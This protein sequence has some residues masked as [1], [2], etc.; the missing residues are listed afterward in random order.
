MR[1]T[2]LDDNSIRCVIS[3]EEMDEHG[4]R[5]DDLMDDRDKA[6]S[7]LRYVLEEADEELGFKTESDSVNVQVSVLP[8]GDIAMM[9]TDDTQS[10][11]EH[12]L[13]H[14]EE[15]IREFTESLEA[16]RKE[17]GI[18]R[19][20]KIDEASVSKW[21]PESFDKKMDLEEG[22]ADEY[23]DTVIWLECKELDRVIRIAKV[24]S[25]LRD[26]ESSLFKYNGTYYLTVK[27][28]EMRK[29]V[30]NMAFGLGE[31]CDH[32]YYEPEEAA[33]VMEHCKPLIMKNA[34]EQLQDL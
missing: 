28:H 2:R 29:V 31:Y 1:F 20:T 25:E 27:L 17:Q 7:F 16:K 24:F 14:M 11:I 23:M 32:L 34:F 30:A 15:G 5:I 8:S 10:A 22:S 33:T 19:K 12:M 21:K 18:E 6:E 9:I 3:G 13:A 4:I 26:Q